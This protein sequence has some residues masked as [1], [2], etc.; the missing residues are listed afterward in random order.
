M[1]L[2]ESLIEGDIKE[3]EPLFA[4]VTTGGVDES[5]VKGDSVELEIK[6]V[7]NDHDSA[8]S[9]ADSNYH[10][11]EVVVNLPPL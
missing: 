5:D 3:G 8:V 2:D 11:P 4:V 9:N 6:S 10:P 1:D 7:H